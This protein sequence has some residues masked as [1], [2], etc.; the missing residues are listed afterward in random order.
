MGV[1]EYGSVI[2]NFVERYVSLIFRFAPHIL[3]L[4]PVTTAASF[5]S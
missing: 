1:W 5:L 4:R 2:F 3:I